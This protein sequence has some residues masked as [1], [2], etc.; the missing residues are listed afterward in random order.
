MVV[1]HSTLLKLLQA[2][3][4][5]FQSDFRVQEATEKRQIRDVEENA[6]VFQ[7]NISAL[8]QLQSSWTSRYVQTCAGVFWTVL[9]VSVRSFIRSYECFSVSCD[10]TY[11]TTK[12]CETGISQNISTALCYENKIQCNRM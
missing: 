1:L 4:G 6:G 8:Y 2:F 12:I 7:L 9:I 10:L 3:F 5:N 11:G